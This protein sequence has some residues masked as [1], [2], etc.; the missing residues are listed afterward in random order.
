MFKKRRNAFPQNGVE[1]VYR[2]VGVQWFGLVLKG[3]VIENHIKRGNELIKIIFD[4]NY[5]YIV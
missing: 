3:V 5:N 2:E 1:N 4:D